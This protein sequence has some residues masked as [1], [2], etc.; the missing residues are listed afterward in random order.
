MILNGLM[1]TIVLSIQMYKSKRFNWTSKDIDRMI[2]SNK[3]VVD[4]NSQLKTDIK[5][6]I[7]YFLNRSYLSNLDIEI[8]ENIICKYGKMD[9]NEFEEY[10]KRR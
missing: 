4:E 1:T 6:I 5:L 7:N 3:K 9:K 10:A 8:A 2:D